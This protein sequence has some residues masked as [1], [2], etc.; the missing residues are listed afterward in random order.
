MPLKGIAFV[1]II[2][3]VIVLTYQKEII[4]YLNS[5]YYD[6]DSFDEESNDEEDNED[7]Q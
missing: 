7:K 2:A 5:R 4:E 6:N 1:F 3:M